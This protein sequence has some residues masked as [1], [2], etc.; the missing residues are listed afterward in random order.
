MA[1]AGSVVAPAMAARWDPVQERWV[2]E[3]SAAPGF[4]HGKAVSGFQPWAGP[5]NGDGGWVGVR[6]ADPYYGAYV[7]TNNPSVTV[8]AWQSWYDSTPM[9]PGVGV[10]QGPWFIDMSVT[11]GANGVHTCNTNHNFP[12]TRPP[13]PTVPRVPETQ[14]A[15]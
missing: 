12:P 11:A 14:P 9:P 15:H 4:N 1:A 8:V 3:C 6:T 2:T 13:L 10:L 7:D 5:A